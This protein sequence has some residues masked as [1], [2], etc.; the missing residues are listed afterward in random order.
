MKD[1][2]VEGR[3]EDWLDNGSVQGCQQDDHIGGTSEDTSSFVH[4]FEPLPAFVDP[5]GT[6][7]MYQPPLH[8]SEQNHHRDPSYGS[9]CYNLKEKSFVLVL[10]YF[11]YCCPSHLWLGLMS[12]SSYHF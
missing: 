4:A 3:V 10:I 9:A 5:Y 8:F 11:D 6:F 7:L 12:H 1:S 2:W